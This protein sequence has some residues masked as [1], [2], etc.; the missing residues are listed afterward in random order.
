[1]WGSAS[2]G[3]AEHTGHRLQ[4]GLPNPTRF[5][6]HQARAVVAG[7][8]NWSGR[9]ATGAV[10]KTVELRARLARRTATGAGRVDRMFRGRRKGGGGL[11]AGPG[12]G[13]LK[14]L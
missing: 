5:R 9:T 2:V 6:L 11:G 10:S 13:A 7:G 4:T 12:Q 14:S 3:S 1:M 8:G